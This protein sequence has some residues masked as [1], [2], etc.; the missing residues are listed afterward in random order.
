MESSEAN[1][2]HRTARRHC[3]G[4]TRADLHRWTIDIDRG[5]ASCDPD[6]SYRQLYERDTPLHVE[7]LVAEIV[8]LIAS[9]SDDP[10]IKWLS[11]RDSVRV[12]VRD[13]ITGQF[14]QTQ[15]GRRKRFRTALAQQL[16]SKGWEIVSGKV[17]LFR[18]VKDATPAVANSASSP[19][20]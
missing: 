13:L 2:R 19:P 6:H 18:R 14:K 9:G 1:I 17:D 8:T 5:T 3:D 4:L 15:Q 7:P 20:R 10:R 16:H 12:L 11:G